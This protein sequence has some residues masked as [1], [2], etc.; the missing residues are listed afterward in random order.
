MRLF[1]YPSVKMCVLGCQKFKNRLKS[2]LVYSDPQLYQASRLL[3]A[4]HR[5]TGS[6]RWPK[7]YF[8]ANT[9]CRNGSCY[10]WII[11]QCRSLNFF[12]WIYAYHFLSTQTLNLIKRHGSP[13]LVIDKPGAFLGPW[14]SWTNLSFIVQNS[15]VALSVLTW[16]NMSLVEAPRIWLRK[17]WTDLEWIHIQ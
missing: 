2:F 3:I 11:L 4:G 10:K 15:K 7:F 14:Q 13:W 6:S 9:I 12:I 5:Q 17:T 8:S 1:S 16:W